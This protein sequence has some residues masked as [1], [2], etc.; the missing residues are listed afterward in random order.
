MATIRG[1][2]TKNTLI[3]T[4]D[5]D[6][7]YG[8]DGNDR[9]DGRDRG[10]LL[11]GGSGNDVLL[12]RD[13]DDR[14]YGDDGDDR[15]DGGGGNDR[16][17]G[18][19][20]A[21]RLDGGTGDDL[22]DGGAGNDLL[23]GRDGNNRL[24]GGTGDDRL[25][26]GSGV[27]R[28]RGDN[29]V[30]RLDGGAGDD[31]LEGGEGN[32][33]LI[34]RAGRDRMIGGNGADM[35]YGH[36][37]DDRIE[38]GSGSD[39]LDG[40]DGADG[41]DGGNSDD[42]LMG[43]GDNDAL[44]GGDGTDRLYGDDGDDLLNGGSGDDDL[45][46]G[47]GND[48]IEG[49][50]GSDRAVF[51]G[52]RGGYE[53]TRDQGVMIVRDI[54]ASDGDDGTD[55]LT[56]VEFLRFRDTLVE[57]V[58]AAPGQL[59][60]VDGTTNRVLENAAAGT[61]VGIAARSIDPDGDAV[62]YSL[63]DDADGRFQIDAATGLVTVKDGSL[64]DFETSRSFDI[65][66]RAADAGGLAAPD[67]TF[68]IAIDNVAAEPTAVADELIVSR[69]IVLTLPAALLLAN[70]IAPA[71]G[72]EVEVAGVGNGASLTIG[73]NGDHLQLVVTGA[74][75]SFIY[76]ISNDRGS[77]SAEVNLGV[78]DVTGGDD[79]LVIA[80]SATRGSF[81]DAGD[82]ND[83]LVGGNGVDRLFGGD[84]DDTLQGGAGDDF[85][86]G[87]EGVDTVNSS[88]L[89]VDV[90]LDLLTSKLISSK[91]IDTLVSIENA[92]GTKYNDNLFGDSG[93]NRL[94]GDGG[95]DRLGGRDGNDTL[96]GGDGN[97]YLEGDA[98]DDIIYGGEGSEYLISNIG[99]DT[100]Y[101]GKDNNFDEFNYNYRPDA[102]NPNPG[103]D[104]VAEFQVG[105]DVI[106]ID[107][108]QSGERHTLFDSNNNA[109][110]DDGDE[111]VFVESVILDGQSKLSTVIDVG[112]ASAAIGQ[113]GVAGVDTITLYGILNPTVDRIGDG[114]GDI[115]CW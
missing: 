36:G 65:V 46:G 89:S 87:G 26:G 52:L 38:G 88:D 32:D 19:A 10:D 86:D 102:I 39:R 74:S 22:V 45:R 55:R 73:L 14:D 40:G 96:F 4:P 70:D 78:V 98:G 58:N 68:T 18:G 2:S 100:I 17:Y 37:D 84:G 113:R 35:V 79:A 57:N 92:I 24:D 108:S 13:G 31:M 29:G 48:A 50:S 42:L 110:L 33:V 15:L 95:N 101:L 9:L 82:G 44:Y 16:L 66:V 93:N 54:D 34:G 21:D 6:R 53:I 81:V 47:V 85:L 97:D 59:T 27:D 112:A 28:L 30:D 25:I 80:S 91:G 64:L 43:R 76:M 90:V 49:G 62:A 56:G 12:G 111:Y 77:S 7:I 23:I 75:S 72:G 20:G 115:Q 105:I 63:V 107:I 60:D 3:G 109:K 11:Y 71:A 114:D 104:I 83:T 8:G 41:L 1:T 106:L 5:A 51:L 69:G 94:V 67:R 99:N 61:A 103:H